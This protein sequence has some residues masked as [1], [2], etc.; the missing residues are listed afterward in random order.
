MVV[1]DENIFGITSRTMCCPRCWIDSRNP[2]CHLV[3]LLDLV[4]PADN[5]D[6]TQE[7][8]DEPSGAGEGT[9]A[10]RL[11]VK[12]EAVNVWWCPVARCA[13]KDSERCHNFSI[14]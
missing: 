8:N 7:C 11:F 13:G 5:M 1:N 3:L 12:R 9:Q 6:R 2:V 4:P 14:I 10:E